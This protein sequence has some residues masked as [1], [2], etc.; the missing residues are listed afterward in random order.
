[1]NDNNKM[2]KTLTLC[3]IDT[4]R[5]RSYLVYTTRI[6]IGKKARTLIDLE[7]LS[8]FV[9]PNFVYVNK[10]PIFNLAIL[11]RL[12]L[13]NS[14]CKLI[15]QA[16]QITHTVSSYTDTSLFYITDLYI[17][18]IVLGICQLEEH[19]IYISF[20]NR[21]LTFNS[22]ACRAGCLYYARL[23]TVL[24]DNSGRTKDVTLPIPKGEEEDVCIISAAAFL[25][26]AKRKDY[27]LFALQPK[28]FAAIGSE[29]NYS[30]FAITSKDYK[31][32]IRAKEAVDPCS[33]LLSYYYDLADVFRYKLDFKLPLYQRTNYAI[34]LKAG[35][36]PPY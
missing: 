12:Q 17:Y 20:P 22:L 11:K 24:I 36:E 18:D 7:A 25:R 3:S 34:K 15:Y 27:E 19:D 9:Y 4:P 1:M 10:L 28:D 13:A 26:I 35:A 30:N 32:F 8:Q 5:S 16:T 6:A 31:T 2:L 29:A 23:Y 33:K 14:S 21:T